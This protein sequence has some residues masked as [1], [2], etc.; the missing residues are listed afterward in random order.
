MVRVEIP[1]SVIGRGMLVVKF[2]ISLRWVR[3]FW[4]SQVVGH[5]QGGSIND[6]SKPKLTSSIW[7]NPSWVTGLGRISS[8]PKFRQHFRLST[9]DEQNPWPA[10]R[11]TRIVSHDLRRP[12]ITCHRDNWGRM[13]KLSNQFCRRDSIKL[14]HHDILRQPPSQRIS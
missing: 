8:I 4:Q 5:H 1:P 3:C 2:L 6:F 10:P 7:S 9:N 11:T 13:V 14:R 12:R